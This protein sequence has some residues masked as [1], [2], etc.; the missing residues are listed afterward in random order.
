MKADSRT[1]YK[2]DCR[3]FR[4]DVP[5]NPHKE[6]GYH[7]SNCSEYSPRT[8]RI[9]VI[10]LGAIGD[11]IRTTPLLEK[12]RSEYE[13]CEIWWLT[14]YPDV[15]P[16]SV[17]RVLTWGY[18]AHV[19]LKNTSFDIAIN[20]DKEPQACALMLEVESADKR[21]FTY[22]DGKPAPI[23]ER[24]HHKFLT[25]LSDELNQENTKSYPQE[26]F[27]ICGYEFAG[28]EYVLD[29]VA[30]PAEVRGE[31]PLIGLNT[32]CGGRWNTRLWAEENWSTLAKS[33]LNHGYDVLLLGGPQEH[34]KNAR[35]A[36]SS[37]A[38]Y[39]GVFGLHE[40]IGL[41]G[42]CDLVVTGVTMAMH[43]AMGL[44]VPI[45]LF[46]NIFNPHEFELYNRGSILEPPTG[47]E[48]YFSPSCSRSEPC[49][50]SITP[51]LVL[52]SVLQNLPIPA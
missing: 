44:K 34:E 4:G 23:D 3:H 22:V 37:G 30:T 32:G 20:L 2:Q 29:A 13:G 15:V 35:L 47:C 9:L 39:A 38:K 16:S 40:F 17:E 5:C 51:D 18:D 1:L 45:V 48:C 52:D 31:K 42:Q 41:I 27:E 7:C 19:I 43:M 26:I 46:V 10:K 11:V 8:Q 36:E 28:E 14:Q 12:L 24:A 33:L 50:E 25:G 21:G 6:H 49:M